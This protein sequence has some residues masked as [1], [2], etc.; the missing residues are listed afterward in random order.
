LNVS[1]NIEEIL[2]SEMELR[3]NYYNGSWYNT[4]YQQID[5]SKE[6]TFDIETDATNVSLEYRLTA[7]TTQGNESFYT[8]YLFEQTYELIFFDTINPAITGE[9]NDTIT[10]PTDWEGTDFDAT[11]NIG[12]NESTWEVNDTR[13]TINGTGYLDT[14]SLG[15]GNYFVEVSVND[16]EGNKGTKNFLLIVNKESGSCDVLFNETSP[17][18]YLESFEV[19]TNCNSDFTLYRNGSVISNDSVQS[20][21][22]GYYNFTVQRTDTQNYSNIRDTEFFTIN[23]INPTASLTNDRAWEFTYDD[24]SANIGISES[25]SG[26]SDVSYILWKDNVDVGSSDS[27]GSAGTYVYKINSTEGENYSATDNLDTDTLIIDQVDIE[28]TA[29]DKS[30]TY[31]EADPSLTYSIT[32]GSLIGGD[33]FSGSLTRESGETAGTYN[34][35]QGTLTAGSNYNETFISG[36]FTINQA[37][38]NLGLISSVG[39][40][41]G[42]SNY[43]TITGTN[44]PEQLTCTLYEEG[45][46]QDNPYVKLFS[47]GSYDFTY[48]TLGNINYT[49]DSIERTLNVNVN[50][51]LVDGMECYLVQTGFGLP[52]D[53]GVSFNTKTSKFICNGTY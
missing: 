45:V 12:V 51:T 14:G 11:D 19:Y 27:E 31:D 44:C 48:S 3:I 16:T 6:Y 13:F 42:A 18:N 46:E 17:L 52:D 40:N 41:I 28:I 32:S 39:W 33:S 36:T 37:T 8:P 10:Y 7:N 21:G 25:N 24:V 1:S 34:I 26:D 35:N 4:E 20:L 22:A 30:K 53:A 43:A 9:D 5:N 2:N 50:A 49:T 15:A 29:D 47:A 38:P 23:K